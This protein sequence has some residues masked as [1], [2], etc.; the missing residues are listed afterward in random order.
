MPWVEV[1]VEPV[2]P[3]HEHGRGRARQPVD[4]VE[5]RGRRR[6]GGAAADARSRSGRAE[7]PGAS[8]GDAWQA[9]VRRATQRGER[10]RR[11]RRAGWWGHRRD[12][13]GP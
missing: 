12:T 3:G 10:R 7:G 9:A 5:R 1:R 11:A 13:T 2:H 4:A 6:T 8:V